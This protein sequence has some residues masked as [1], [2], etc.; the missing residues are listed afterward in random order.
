MKKLNT[1]FVA[2]VSFVLSG[3]GIFTRYADTTEIPDNLFGDIAVSAGDEQQTI[4]TVSWRD[5]FTDPKLQILIDSALSRNTD[6]AQAEMLADQAELVLKNIRLAYLPSL[7]FNPSINIAPD[8]GYSLPLDLDWSLSGFGSMT[9]RKRETVAN[10]FAAMDMLE[11]ARAR[12]VCLTAKAYSQLLLLDREYEIIVST[13]RIWSEVLETQKALMENGRAYSTSVNQMKASLLGVT[14]QK[15]DI[16]NSIADLEASICRMIREVPGHIERSSW[17]EF[18]LPEETAYGIPASILEN[19]PDVRAAGRNL[20]AAYY[21]TNQARCAMLPGLSLYG[22]IGWGTNGMPIA[23]P[24]E[25]IY[26]AIASISQPVFAQGRLRTTLKINKLKQQLAADQYVQA[27]VDAGNEVNVALRACQLSRDKKSIYDEQ[28]STLQ[29][30]Y[31]ATQELMNNG[32]ATY[33]E[34]LTAQEALLNSQL[35]QI[36]NYFDGMNSL[37]DLYLA[38][39]G[40]TK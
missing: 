14:I 24:A 21:V 32:K 28:V 35:A 38:L 37:I 8:E 26:S 9:N 34:V 2:L 18:S 4:G 5:Y 16:E 19:R 12:M 29:D 31:S 1:A 15:M 36:A 13:E 39:G 20:E 6:V 23:N 17:T 3:C 27:M 22:M 25:L 30:A 40:G 7:T 33:I 11:D 10:S